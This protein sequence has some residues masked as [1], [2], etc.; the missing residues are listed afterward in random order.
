MSCILKSK[1]SV[2]I[3]AQKVFV[4]EPIMIHVFEVIGST[5]RISGI[6]FASWTCLKGQIVTLCYKMLQFYKIV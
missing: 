6:I 3:I 2:S 5:E 4:I 1:M